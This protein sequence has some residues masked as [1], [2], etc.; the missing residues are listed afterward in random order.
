MAKD[1]TK[2]IRAKQKAILDTVRTVGVKYHE[3]RYLTDSREAIFKPEGD[4]N[5]WMKCNWHFRLV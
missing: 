5:R 3:E 2:E 1:A 4:K